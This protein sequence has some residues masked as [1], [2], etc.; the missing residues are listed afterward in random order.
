MDSAKTRAMSL[1]RDEDQLMRRIREQNGQDL[2][3]VDYCP[4]VVC[5]YNPWCGEILTWSNRAL[6]KLRFY[7]QDSVW[8]LVVF[9]GTRRRREV[10][11]CLK[12][13]RARVVNTLNFSGNKIG[14]EERVDRM[15]F[16][17]VCW[18]LPRL[19]VSLYLANISVSRKQLE[20]ILNS[21]RHLDYL[22][23]DTCKIDTKELKIRQDRTPDVKKIELINC[24]S[25]RKDSDT[26][27]FCL[28]GLISC[29][30]ISSLQFSLKSICFQKL[31]PSHK[32]LSKVSKKY[33]NS[34][35]KIIV[36]DGCS[37][38]YKRVKK[39]SHKCNLF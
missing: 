22:C 8:L 19:T 3:Y 26:V 9:G 2:N 38:K 21:I 36:I 25:N 15:V 7:H 12:R 10:C 33:S 5:C 4:E 1:L 14:D 23:L 34:Q 28:E 18:V 20:V 11:K 35:V 32:E 30:S 27:P 6:A 31:V 13:F 29:I 16:G 24:F 37:L 39:N 17:A